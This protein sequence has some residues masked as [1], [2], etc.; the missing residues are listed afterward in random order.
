MIY[1]NIS[2]MTPQLEEIQE[3]YQVRMKTPLANPDQ[4]TA[5]SPMSVAVKGLNDLAQF[6][7]R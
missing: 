3:I 4:M 5:F 7:G 6:M 1:R 2:V